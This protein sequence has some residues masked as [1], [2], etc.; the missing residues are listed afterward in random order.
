MSVTSPFELVNNTC[1]EIQ[2]A[3]HYEDNYFEKKIAEDGLEFQEKIDDSEC[4]VMKIEAGK[5]FHVPIPLIEASLHEFGTDLGYVWIRPHEKM[6]EYSS[7]PINLFSLVKESC[8]LFQKGSMSPETEYNLFCPVNSDDKEIVSPYCYCIEVKRSPIVTRFPGHGID[9]NRDKIH[10]P[11]FS[12]SGFESTIAEEES[13][14][15]SM[16]K[17]RGQKKKQNLEED[18]S[19]GPVAYTLVIH[20]PIVIENLLPET[21]MYTLIDPSREKEVWF[22]IL[23]PGESVPIYRYV[24]ILAI[25]EHLIFY[26]N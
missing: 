2:L 11:K 3:Y 23:S 22:Q 5:S 17:Q 15:V 26:I 6:A 12:A 18:E 20:P 8:E 9:P 25:L 4:Y 19:H 14:G 13:L 1:H 16:R 24:F 21:A 10:E 7:R